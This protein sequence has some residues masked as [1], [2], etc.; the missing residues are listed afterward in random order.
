MQHQRAF[1]S[2]WPAACTA[3]LA[4]G[5]MQLEAS[6][7][8][9]NPSAPQWRCIYFW[10]KKVLQRN[11]CVGP[12]KIFHSFLDVMDGYMNNDTSAA[13]T[14]WFVPAL[15]PHHFID[16]ELEEIMHLITSDS[17]NHLNW[18]LVLGHQLKSK[19][20]CI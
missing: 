5:L 3:Q 11:V 10:P 2:S 15:L 13:C 7:F 12:K 1:H 9:L 16:Q 18:A 14:C 6:F 8:W 17:R 4:R 20:T 19:E